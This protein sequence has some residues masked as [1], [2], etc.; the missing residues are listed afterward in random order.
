MGFESLI[1][2][3]FFGLLG[4]AMFA[5][6]KRGG[7]VVPLVCGLVLM[8]LPALMPSVV[9]MVLACSIVAAVPLVVSA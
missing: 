6:G 9:A 3:L 4:M 2:S 1:G 8:V 5:F 7:R